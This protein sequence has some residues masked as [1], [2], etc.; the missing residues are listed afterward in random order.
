MKRLLVV[1]MAIAGMAVIA[2][3]PTVSNVTAKQR[4]PW[5]GLV[6][7]FCTVSGID[8]TTNGLKFVVAAVMPDSS[9]I[10]KVSHFWVVENGTNSASHKVHAAGD[11]RLLWNA[12]A[13]LG[14][15]IYSNMVVRVTVDDVHGKVQLWEG[16][17]YWADTNIGA[18]EPWEYGYYFWWGD[19][20]G[21]K[22]EN[23]SWVASDGSSSDFSFEEANTPTNNK[24]ENSL[25]R[26][27]WIT[28]DNILAP[29]HDAAHVQWG[30]E[31]RMPTNQELS[32]LT[33]MC[34]FIWTT[35]NDVKGY[36]FSG[37]GAYASASIFLPAAGVAEYK[38]A[39]S[40][41]D[42]FASM[43]YYWSSVP[44]RHSYYEGAW[45]L[46]FWE[47]YEKHLIEVDPF[48][49]DG[50]PIRPIQ[51]FTGVA[52]A[53]GVSGDSEF[54]LLDT[55]MT[56]ESPLVDSISGSWN[57]SWI[58]GDAEAMVVITDNGTEVK[59]VFGE[60]EF[61]HT[62]TDVGRHELSYITYIEGVALNEVY[63]TTVFKDW[64]YVV[65]DGGAVMID[66]AQKDGEIVIPS[67]IDGYPVTG[68]TDGI[69]AERN[70]RK[71]VF[72]DGAMRIADNFFAGCENLETIDIPESVV[73]IGTNVFEACS[74]LETVVT[75][76]LVLYQGWCLG[77]AD[78]ENGK[79]NLII[80]EGIR[81]IA[82]GAFEGEYE[83]EAVAFPSTLRFV[84]A[85]A[86]K[87]CTG[88]EEIILPEGVE[89]VDRDAFR[90]CT[91]VQD[92]SLPSTLREIGDGAFANCS[93]LMTVEIPDGVVE[94]G[95]VAFSNCWRMLS[96][97][98]P[99]SVTN[100]GAG[101]FIECRRL[102]GVTVPLGLATLAELF[103]SAYG[104]IESVIVVDDNESGRVTLPMV[105]GMFSGCGSMNN[106]TLP[107]DLAEVSA[108]AFVG[109][110][111]MVAFSLPNTVTN[112]G[113]RAFRDLKQ[114]T[115]FVFPTGLVIIGEQSFSN[116]DGIDALSLPDGLRSIGTR[117]FQWV[118]RLTR[119]DIPESVESIGWWAFYGCTRIRTVSL[120]GDVTTVSTAFPSAH[121]L[122]TEA[123]VVR[124]NV[125]AS[126]FEGCEALAYVEIKPGVTTIGAQAFKDCS[127]LV[128]VEMP[129]ELT[130]IGAQAFMG[131]SALTT[132][133]IPSGVTALGTEAF[134]GCLNLSQL[135]LPRNLTML[136][137]YAFAECLSLSELVVPESVTSLGANVFTGCS[138]LRSIRF[139]GN[140][141]SYSSTAY[142][143]TVAAL[144]TYVP[145]GSMGW[146]GVPTSR[147]LPEFWPDGT[148]HEITWWEPN[149]FM[150]NFVA[151]NGAGVVTT[152]V[153][154]VT[155][156]TYSLPQNTV[157]RGAV[158]GGWWTTT[159]GG[160]RV[161]AV[162]QVA[163]TRP[164]TF[165]AHWTFNRYSVIFDANGG[166][167]TMGPQELM[168][169]TAANLS[170]CDFSRSGYAFMGWSTE[171]DGEVAYTNAA[172][173]LDLAYEQGASV[174]LYAVWEE[175]EWT[176]ADF[177]D[178]S[179]LVFSN[180]TVAEWT[181]DWE[182]HKVGGVS[183]RSGAI[184]AAAEWGR[185]N[186]ILMA[187]AVGE[188]S[189]SFWW[190]AHCEEMD[191]EYDEWYDYAVF[192]ID[193]VEVAKIAG[194]SGWQ[195]VEY[196]VAGAGPH[197]LAWTFSRDDYDE[198][199]ATWE[200]CA[201]VDGIMWTPVPVTVTFA[202]GGATEGTAP[203]IVTKYEGYELVLPGA[204][205]LA[206][207]AY[208]FMGWSDGETIYASGAVYVFG[209]TN[210]TLA[211][212]WGEKVWTLGEAV[213]AEPILFTTG[214][215]AD[216]AVDGSTGWTNGVSA[217]SGTITSGQTTWIE[218][219]V[220]GPG[221]LTYCWNVM[222]GVYRNTPFAYAKVT[223]DGI[224]QAQEY[225]SGGWKGETIAVEGEGTHVIRWTYMHTSSRTADGDC[226]WLDAVA[227]TPVGGSTDQTTMTPEPVPYSYFNM[228]YPALLA[229][230][231]GNYEAAANAT[232]ANGFNKV[233]EC[234]VA[235]ISP[236]NETAKFAA[237]IEMKDG[238]PVVTWKP[239]LNTNGTVRIY[240]VYG[241]ETLEN[242][243][244]WQYPTN[245]LHKFFKVTVEM[246]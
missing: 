29:E 182:I 149:R 67:A 95:E 226:A 45:S 205:T 217:K 192:T 79:R 239:D 159:D 24:W 5:N 11:Y 178:C 58:G 186:T 87:D 147:A 40:D 108:D 34:D 78:M 165:Y 38:T 127:A 68:I 175:R 139:V 91:Y 215:N 96:A 232:A 64:K 20:V 118:S 185:T 233:W 189:G 176:L 66:M 10:N 238:A 22:R 213:D 116:C 86:F 183:L 14:A 122:M 94:I 136:P 9:D 191:D 50:L 55:V 156:T 35:V 97:S 246:P 244:D 77:Y 235:G 109:C 98:I 69:F 146:D 211:A 105:P 117:A 33:N 76:G 240:K 158:F 190:K 170:E 216:W 134:R 154:Q 242:G 231:G 81:G 51:D 46:A 123:T 92:I 228:N 200:N 30:G 31:W 212:V 230:Y 199:G 2:A 161:T 144:V 160:A 143:G 224:Q 25:K 141:P 48:R 162:T 101:A 59:R 187:T 12:Q 23:N 188:G 32:D 203:E 153:E 57:S 73:R 237:K 204:G 106:L 194:D 54:F 120:P 6:D 15:V 7:I 62:L 135:A 129:S 80:P 208:V 27:G 198:D 39:P 229:E 214:G 173:V 151:D 184:E 56:L 8:G 83:I 210:T 124:G 202:A 227:W 157:R 132:I 140:A 43:C 193:G 85:R 137:D 114:L 128:T 201:W 113:A 126:L 75:N 150:V 21:Y 142:G 19:T 241:S 71:I 84:G 171:P 138:L 221:T 225:S 41:F 145:N 60:G 53:A 234:Y 206:N 164:H 119:V 195:Q 52:M 103:P 90:N 131:C 220:V 26:E 207:G 44:G 61:V 111:N 100:V 82:A 177:V 16:G 93:Q 236:T 36:I 197:E 18:E 219:T 13:D 63:T 42:V 179:N 37:K 89:V 70:V 218:M 223:V 243:G 3:T 155:G 99:C 174:T 1:M 209:S 180:D 17:P 167:G 102:T 168:V 163:L 72:S 28:A 121:K 65:R 74:A 148:T 112:I 222:G 88:I 152:H 172:E 125:I 130:A 110:T 49:W 196:T 47:D 245:S 104:K 107:E 169:S 115:E 4:F 181:P 133:G 166:E